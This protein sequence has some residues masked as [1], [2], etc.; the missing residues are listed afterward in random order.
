MIG[1]PNGEERPALTI[2]IA[3]WATPIVGLVALV[4]GL[5]GGYALR[6]LI[7]PGA[8]GETEAEVVAPT[9]APTQVA[10]NQP[11]GGEESEVQ[12]GLQEPQATLPA[13]T[14]PEELM[15]FLVS[16]TKHFRGEADAPVTIIE[17]SDFQ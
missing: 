8:N 2:T 16:Q 6:P 12:T 9:R 5:L 17:F 7:T 3:S 11:V 14:G 4:I 10:E 13:I 15:D 1:Q